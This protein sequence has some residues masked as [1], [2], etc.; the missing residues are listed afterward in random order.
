MNKQDCLVI[1]T[2]IKTHGV[3]GELIVSTKNPNL[4]QNIKESVFLEIEGLL[5]PFFV[6]KIVPTSNNH[7]RILFDC[8][9]SEADA[10]K[11]IRT[12]VFVSLKSVQSD[13]SYENNKNILKGFLVSDAKYG[14]VG[15]VTDIVDSDTNPLIVINNNGKEILIPIHHDL[16]KDVDLNNKH[17]YIDAPEGLID[18]YME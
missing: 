10:K 13:I 7:F 3:K 8:V 15:V 17:L 6:E 11:I 9:K 18:L 14:N 1:G 2:I 4:L 12:T 5:V 16:I